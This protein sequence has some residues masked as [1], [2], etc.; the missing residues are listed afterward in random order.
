[1]KYQ[2]YPST[3][4]LKHT[5][6][7]YE[8]RKLPYVFLSNTTTYKRCKVFHS[9]YEQWP[10]KRSVTKKR[11]QILLSNKQG[12]RVH[13]KIVQLHKYLMCCLTSNGNNLH[14]KQVWKGW[15]N[16]A[17]IY[18]GN[19]IDYDVKPYQVKTTIVNCTGVRLKVLKKLTAHSWDVGIPNMNVTQIIKPWMRYNHLNSTTVKWKRKR[20]WMLVVFLRPLTSIQISTI[21]TCSIPRCPVLSH[22]LVCS[23]NSLSITGIGSI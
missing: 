10:F 6:V 8:S 20:I 15:K 18:T 4:I 1:M 7:L 22:S 9:T 14:I 3:K 19:T 13:N 17:E 16:R 12:Y 21:E 23:K 5:D 2:K 11:I